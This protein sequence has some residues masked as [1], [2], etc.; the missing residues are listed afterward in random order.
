LKTLDQK[1]EWTERL[2]DA[3]L[4]QQSQ[5]MDT[6]QELRTKAQ[7]AGNLSSNAQINVT[8]GD[9][10]ID[11]EPANP[12]VVYVPYYDPAV[13]YGNWWWP[14]YPPVFWSPWPD[15]GWYS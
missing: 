4:A 7:Q 6:V 15:Y 9:G 14:A 10:G 3:F 2:G 12:E 1:I 8:D 5:V 13:V 11:I